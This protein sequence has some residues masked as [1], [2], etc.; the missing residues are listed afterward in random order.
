M[1]RWSAGVL[2]ALWLVGCGPMHPRGRVDGGSA[3]Q[4]TPSPPGELAGDAA[5]TLTP[6]PLPGGGEPAPSRPSADAAPAAPPPATPDAAPAAS[7]DLPLSTCDRWIVNRQGRRVK[8][9]GV[10]WYGGSDTKLV[11]GGLDKVSME[12]IVATITGLGF[13]SV[14]LPFSNEMLHVTRPAAPDTIA[15]NPRLMGKTPIEIFDA[16]VEALT[17]AGVYVILNNHSTHA[18]WCCNFDDDGL[19]YTAEVSEDEWIADWEWVVKR[20]RTNRRVVGADLRNEIRIAKPLGGLAGLLPRFPNW[21]DGGDTDWHAAATRAGKR[22]QAANPDLLIIV[23]GINSADDLTGVAKHP[24]ELD[25]P[26][27]VVYEAHQYGFFRPGFPAIPGIGPATYGSMNAAGLSSASRQQWGYIT[28]PGKPYTAPL[29]LGEF[30]DSASSDPAWLN[31]LAAYLRTLDADY[32]WWALNGGPK[33][34]G[35]DEPFGLLDDDWKTVRRDWR[36]TLLQSLQKPTRGPGLSA[37]DAC[38]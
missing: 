36:L 9:A 35:G 8:L 4:G 17:A 11:P 23:E 7:D 32:A 15:A 20:Y 21:G 26:H 1:A 19:W 34:A 25:V 10:N 12:S 31:N 3:S 37:A 38:P 33:A 14:R 18:M 16:A 28:D 30:G 22:V 24:V 2:V 6:E 29:W 5:R 27:K 13:N